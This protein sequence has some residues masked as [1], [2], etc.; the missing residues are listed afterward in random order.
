MRPTYEPAIQDAFWEEKGG[1]KL[2]FSL[3]VLSV[4]YSG[5]GGGWGVVMEMESMQGLFMWADWGALR[6]G[7]CKQPALTDI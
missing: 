7:P 5:G 2:N 3:A 6:Q 4:R 1:L